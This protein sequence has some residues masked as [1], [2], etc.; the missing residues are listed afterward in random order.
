MANVKVRLKDASNNIL[1]PETDWSVVRN[2]PSNYPTDWELSVANK[3]FQL[4]KN[5]FVG[6]ANVLRVT[7][8]KAFKFN[9][10]ETFNYSFGYCSSYKEGMWNYTPAFYNRNWG[11]GG[12][13]R[14]T[15]YRYNVTDNAWESFTLDGNNMYYPLYIS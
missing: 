5:N 9:S 15:Y 13:V 7:G 11:T 6:G 3:P 12:Y 2:K 1:H 10:E 14:T 8:F 4:E